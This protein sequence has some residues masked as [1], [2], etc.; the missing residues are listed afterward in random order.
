MQ[1]LCKA[2]LA[3]VF[4]DTFSHVAGHNHRVKIKFSEVS[5]EFEVWILVFDLFRGSKV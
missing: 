4:E 2:F 3:F 1:Y 5:L